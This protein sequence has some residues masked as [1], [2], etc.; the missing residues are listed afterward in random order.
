MRIFVVS[1]VDLSTQDAQRTHLMEKWKQLASLGH[2]VHLWAAQRDTDAKNWKGITVRSVPRITVRGLNDISYQFCL[3]L[4]LLL[5]ALRRVPAVIYVR[6]S[7]LDFA[8]LAVSVVLNVPLV[9]EVPGPV[10]EEAVY[11]DISPIK[12]R[13]INFLMRLKLRRAAAV[14]SVTEGIKDVLYTDYSVDKE[15]VYVVGNGANTELFRPISQSLAKQ[16]L[17]LQSHNSYIGFVGSLYPWHGVQFLVTASSRVL[18]DNPDVAF[19]I[20]GDGK[21]K[22]VL[23]QQAINDGVSENFIF[24]GVVPYLEVPYFV[25]A[26]DLV[27]LPLFTKTSNDSGYSPL[28]LYEYMACGKPIIASRLNGVEIIEKKHL[29]KL[30][31]PKNPDAL[32]AA[33]IALLENRSALEEMGQRGRSIAVNQFDWGVIAR[34]VENVMNNAIRSQ[35]EEI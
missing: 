7:S 11:Y 23:Q 35:D 2:E 30:V 29:G 21:M 1:M 32:A 26:C 20:V 13:L 4:S 33:I 24:T 22:E 12:L 16:R 34:Q 17:G 9:I 10:N 15:K 14:I 28:K 6:N 8:P 19:L 18:R 3:L 25:A 27:I 31:E 5:H